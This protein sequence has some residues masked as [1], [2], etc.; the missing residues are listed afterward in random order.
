[1]TA[2]TQTIE[3]LQELPRAERRDA[4][5]TLVVAEFKT[6]LFMSDDEDLPTD[7]SFFELGL[8]S[9]RI[10]EIKQRLEDL[11]GR[12]IDTNSLFNR[13]TLGQLLVHLTD[14]VLPE[15]FHGAAAA[16]A[17]RPEAAE[18]KEAVDELLKELYQA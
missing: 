3:R 18:H 15:L 12:E 9:L 10:T 1:M 11:L 4:L 16:A 14:E 2:S 13:P 5:E 17:P 6:T 7:T 8:T